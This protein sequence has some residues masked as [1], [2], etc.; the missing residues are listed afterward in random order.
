MTS[1]TVHRDKIKEWQVDP[2]VWQKSLI[3][4]HAADP[5]VS[6]DKSQTPQGSVLN[7]HI[8]E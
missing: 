6:A 8:R 2:L 3:L 1:M 5:S 7:F 4:S